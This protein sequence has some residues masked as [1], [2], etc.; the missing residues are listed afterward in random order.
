M[1][2]VLTAKFAQK[3]FRLR[4]PLPRLHRVDRPASA[5]DTHLKIGHGFL[6][7]HPYC[8]QTAST[9]CSRQGTDEQRAWVESEDKRCLWLPDCEELAVIRTPRI[10][11][12]FGI[13]K[14]T[15]NLFRVGVVV[16]N[17]D[18][19]RSEI[20]VLNTAL[21][22]GGAIGVFGWTFRSVEASG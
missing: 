9:T 3:R 15:V 6:A 8:L 19:R 20:R 14:I 12:S 13:S 21:I 7:K 1:S 11:F 22:A 18:H 17:A 2:L 4:N 5:I 16:G 10:R